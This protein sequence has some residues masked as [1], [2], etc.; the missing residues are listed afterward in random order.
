MLHHAQ[1]KAETCTACTRN[2]IIVGRINC[3]NLFQENKNSGL[4]KHQ[5]ADNYSLYK[6]KKQL[7]LPFGPGEEN[8][9]LP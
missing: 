3:N 5:P 9:R 8:A 4:P 7:L 6:I 2:N 1:Q